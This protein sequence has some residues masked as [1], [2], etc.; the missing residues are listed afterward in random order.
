MLRTRCATVGLVALA[1]AC[2]KDHGTV[3]GAITSGRKHFDTSASAASN[4][5]DSA[6]SAARGHADTA[7]TRGKGHLDSAL[8]STRQAA[9]RV[10]SSLRAKMTAPAAPARPSDTTAAGT[11]APGAASTTAMPGTGPGAAPTTAG[12]TDTASTAPTVAGRARLAALS[13]DQVKQLQTAL[14]SDGCA[15]GPVDGV[16]G[17]KTRAGIAC[18]MRKHHIANHDLDA[19]YRALDLDLGR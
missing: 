16:V 3:S 17:A 19:L 2:N 8:S 9:A 11:L 5:A 18:S 12:P 10:D 1:V 13:G 6:L 4:S 7:L 14:N 15:A